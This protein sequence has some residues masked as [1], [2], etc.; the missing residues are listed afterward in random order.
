M[1]LEQFGLD[2]SC[3]AENSLVA[4]QFY[5]V[6]LSGADLQVDVCDGATDLVYG[7]LQNKPAA[8]AAAAVRRLGITKWVSNGSGTAIAVGDKVG[9]DASGKCVKKASAGN[10]VAGTALSASSADGT[11]IDVDLTPNAI[12]HA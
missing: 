12:I 6:E 1:A 7:V 9:T 3:V 5:A 4:K 11:I 8:G 10:F 2:V